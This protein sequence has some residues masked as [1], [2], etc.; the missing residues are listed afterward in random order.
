MCPDVMPNGRYRFLVAVGYEHEVVFT[1]S[2]PSQL[3]VQMHSPFEAE[4][5]LMRL[6]VIDPFSLDV[7]ADGHKVPASATDRPTLMSITGANQFNPQ[8]AWTVA[9]R[10]VIASC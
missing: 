1:N 4:A 8:S 10:A 9:A 3:L 2:L 5:V 6:F 7:Y